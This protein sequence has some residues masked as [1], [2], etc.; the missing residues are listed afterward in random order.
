M[1]TRYQYWHDQGVTSQVES[2]LE[3]AVVLADR[4]SFAFNTPSGIP[5]NNLEFPTNSS[6]DS[7]NGV[8]T[9]G[10]LILEWTR[11]SD[12]TGNPKYANLASKA[13]SYLLNPKPVEVGE[14][15]PGMLGTRLDIRSGLFLD[16]EGGWSG[17][18]DSFYEYLLKMWI[19][20]PSENH[21]YRDRRVIP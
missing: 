8:A 4:L 13:E 2:L 21:L 14:P 7:V 15:F 3:Q 10:T 12:I 11:L 16:S 18:T 9:I 17:G 6:F 5:Y 19:Y 1:L 20:S